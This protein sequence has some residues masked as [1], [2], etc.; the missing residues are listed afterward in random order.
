MFGEVIMK[1]DFVVFNN[2]VEDLCFIGFLLGY[3][4]LWLFFGM[5][6]FL[7][8]CLVGMVGI[9]NWF[10]GYDDVI[11]DLLKLWSL[12]CVFVVCGYWVEWDWSNVIKELKC[13]EL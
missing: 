9:V 4:L 5:F 8:N 7:N 10:Y 11:I 1:E 12:V 13:K 2:L 3:F 6:F